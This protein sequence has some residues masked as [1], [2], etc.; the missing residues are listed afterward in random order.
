MLVTAFYVSG[1][2]AKYQNYVVVIF[3]FHLKS[4]ELEIAISFC[5]TRWYMV[6][7]GKLSS[8]KKFLIERRY[9]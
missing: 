8:K 7:V 1:R 2:K 9:R 3:I 5:I 4:N 6:T